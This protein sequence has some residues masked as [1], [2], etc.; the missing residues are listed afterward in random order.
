MNSN[1]YRAT[2]LHVRCLYVTRRRALRLLDST[3]EVKSSAYFD[4]TCHVAEVLANLILERSPKSNTSRHSYITFL[5]GNNR[6]IFLSKRMSKKSY[7]LS[8][9]I[10]LTLLSN[11][12]ILGYLSSYNRTHSSVKRF[13]ERANTFR[14]M[15]PQKTLIYIGFDILSY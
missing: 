1:C 7:F 8:K 9:R 2:W 6:E 13:Y 3:Q 12:L 15:C 10:F 11:K 14:D 4:Y 5:S